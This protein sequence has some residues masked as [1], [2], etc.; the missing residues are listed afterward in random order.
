V[1]RAQ[2]ID[3]SMV[4]EQKPAV[5]V[6]HPAGGDV[7]HL[8]PLRSSGLTLRR[9]RFKRSTQRV[10]R[11]GDIRTPPGQRSSAEL[12]Q[13]SSA[14]VEFMTIIQGRRI[15]P[16]KW[17]S[18]A[19]AAGSNTA[20]SKEQPHQVESDLLIG[21]DLTRQAAPMEPCDARRPS[22]CRELPEASGTRHPSATRAIWP[23]AK[24]RSRMPTAEAPRSGA[25]RP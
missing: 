5:Y 18:L 12:R 11:R 6:Q 24:R 21:T 2:T 4:D 1:N 22:A 3:A 8:L 9:P 15:A 20:R 13:V 19:P 16:L 25:E 7:S 23:A 14:A 10:Q 17:A